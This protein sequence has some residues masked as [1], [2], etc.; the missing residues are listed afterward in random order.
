[1][2]VAP[3]SMDSNNTPPKNSG[4]RQKPK[5]EKT[6]T[7]QINMFKLKQKLSDICRLILEKGRNV[8]K[9]LGQENIWAG[10]TW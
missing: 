9:R 2:K 5:Q 4:S 7:R 10:Y 3:K 1:M 8:D 6:D